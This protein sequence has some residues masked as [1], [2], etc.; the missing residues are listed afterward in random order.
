[1]LAMVS[2]IFRALCFSN[3]RSRVME[4]LSRSFS[5]GMLVLT[6][7]SLSVV[8]RRSVDLLIMCSSNVVG[9]QVKSGWGVTLH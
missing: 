3:S 1:M 5:R 8:C 6:V 4:T 9:S 7:D 2:R